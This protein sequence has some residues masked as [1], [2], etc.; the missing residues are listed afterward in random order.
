M[1]GRW[2]QQEDLEI[3]KAVQENPE[4]IKHSLIK[5]ANKINRSYPATSAH[6]Y[7]IRNKYGAL[8]MMSSSKTAIVNHKNVFIT[9]HI[10]KYKSNKSIFNKILKFLKI[11]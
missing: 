7:K 8:F 10:Q 1:A 4:N 6:Y 3:M 5:V 2:T 9:K 11:K